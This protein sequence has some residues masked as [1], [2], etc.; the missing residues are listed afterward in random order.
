[1]LVILLYHEAW[2]ARVMFLIY[3]FFT[4]QDIILL[5]PKLLNMVRRRRVYCILG[6]SEWRHYFK[7]IT[8]S[9]CGPRSWSS[10]PRRS[11]RRARDW[12]WTRIWRFA[13]KLKSNV[14]WKS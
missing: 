4:F 8:I 5:R 3:S 11:R 12:G 10:R 7:I 13:Q 6:S 9:S 14:I 1:V 2:D